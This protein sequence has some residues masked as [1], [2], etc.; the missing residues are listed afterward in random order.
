MYGKGN[1][2]AVNC[3]EEEEGRIVTRI[4]IRGAK[5][6]IM[7]PRG[8]KTCVDMAGPEPSSDLECP[9]VESYFTDSDVGGYWVG[10]EKSDE[11]REPSKTTEGDVRRSSSKTNMR[12]RRN[13]KS[14]R[15]YWGIQN[16]TKLMGDTERS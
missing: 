15:T 16:E 10:R 7:M 8:G 13:H 1:F 14:D 9:G 3:E 6:L 5:C 2:R 11:F 4:L 12:G